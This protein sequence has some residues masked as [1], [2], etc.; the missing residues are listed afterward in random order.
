METT[1]DINLDENEDT[2]VDLEKN[3]EDDNMTNLSSS[4]EEFDG[5]IFDSDSE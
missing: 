3:I 4:M 5:F 2:L 1:S